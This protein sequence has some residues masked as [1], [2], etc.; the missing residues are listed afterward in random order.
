MIYL[1]FPTIF[2]GLYSPYFEAGARFVSFTLWMNIARLS[3][4]PSTNC[5]V[6]P[7]ALRAKPPM[8]YST[9]ESQLL[10]VVQV[11]TISW[12]LSVT[13]IIWA[14]DNQ[15]SK[16]I[17]LRTLRLTSIRYVY[18]LWLII[19]DCSASNYVACKT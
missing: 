4:P 13:K 5:T 14:T 3:E 9:I 15:F 10:Y 12:T 1:W 17:L 8:P 2:W 16:I 18:L 7:C 11:T 6:L 19:F